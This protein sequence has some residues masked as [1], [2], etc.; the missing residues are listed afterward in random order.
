MSWSNF[1]KDIKNARFD[2][3]ENQL[4]RMKESITELYSI[5]KFVFDSPRKLERPYNSLAAYK[6]KRERMYQ[7]PD[8]FYKFQHDNVLIFIHCRN[9]KTYSVAVTGY[10]PF[11][12]NKELKQRYESYFSAGFDFY[13]SFT[14]D[15]FSLCRSLF[16]DI[17]QD[18]VSDCITPE[19][20]A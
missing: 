4:V 16:Y 13:G 3:T 20:I 1:E 2:F 8:E 15:D 18:F 7:S 9:K 17:V 5:F 11:N 10:K 19:F 14:R 6:Y 12:C